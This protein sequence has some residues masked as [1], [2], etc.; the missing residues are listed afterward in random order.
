MKTPDE[1]KK[2]LECC[3]KLKTNCSLCPYAPTVDGDCMNGL[4]PDALAYIQQLERER[5]AAVRDLYD[6][7]M[8]CELCL[9][10]NKPIDEEPCKSCAN[11][12]TVNRHT[13]WQWRGAQEV[14]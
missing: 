4:V 1:I 8:V 13:N 11:A 5:D 3:S 9:H 7:G 14:E 6:Y 10:E 2:G 12:S